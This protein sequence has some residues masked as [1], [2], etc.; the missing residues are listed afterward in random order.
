[1]QTTIRHKHGASF[2]AEIAA[3]VQG[4]P[5]DLTGMTITSQIRA[6]AGS[7]R[8]PGVVVDVVD[9]VNGL[10]AIHAK[11]TTQWPVTRLEWDVRMV[12]ADGNVSAT[13]TVLIDCERE[14]TR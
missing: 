12:D 10:I 2:R 5:L 8:V 4:D 13:D 11:D 3:T 7:Y 6:A 14:V 1:V 9:A